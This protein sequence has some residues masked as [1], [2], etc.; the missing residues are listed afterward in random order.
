MLE[1]HS[2]KQKNFFFL[3]AN[4][5]RVIYGAVSVSS[6]VGGGGEGRLFPQIFQETLMQEKRVYYAHYSPSPHTQNFRTFLRSWVSRT[7]QPPAWLARWG[8]FVVS[9]KA[10]NFLE[11]NF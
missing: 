11:T 5:I 2:E 7:R 9:V 8:I 3:D 4:P 6:G 10:E 1:Q